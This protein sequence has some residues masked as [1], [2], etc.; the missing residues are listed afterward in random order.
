M[1]SLAGNSGQAELIPTE[2]IDVSDLL[3]CEDAAASGGP[4]GGRDGRHG[5]P[6]AESQGNGNLET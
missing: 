4:G 5:E 2:P 6:L 1:I 3:A